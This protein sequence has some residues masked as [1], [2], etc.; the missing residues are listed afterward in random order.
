MPADAAYTEE[1]YRAHLNER[2][3]SLAK[4]GAAF[5][6]DS[7]AGLFLLS[8]LSLRQASAASATCTR[9]S[10]CTDHTCT[11]MLESSCLSPEHAML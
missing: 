1:E 9:M 8:M 10:H 4:L 11:E 2:R 7:M 6:E 5:I 3:A